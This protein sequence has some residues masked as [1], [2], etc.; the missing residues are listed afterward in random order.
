MT[1]SHFTPL[2]SFHRGLI[3][4]DLASFSKSCLLALILSRYPGIWQPDVPYFAIIFLE[5]F[6]DKHTWGAGGSTKDRSL[7]LA[8]LTQAEGLSTILHLTCTNMEQGLVDDVLQVHPDF[9]F[10]GGFSCSVLLWKGS[11]KAGNTKYSCPSRRS[12]PLHLLILHVLYYVVYKRSAARERGVDP[13]WSP[14]Y[15]SR[16]SRFIYTFRARFF[17]LVL[18][19]RCR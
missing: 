9:F 13:F 10:F 1:L 19:R 3:R 12:V 7:E 16:R 11:Q 2:N 6:G 18:H 5:S 8:G 4:S 14:L 15:S 17:F